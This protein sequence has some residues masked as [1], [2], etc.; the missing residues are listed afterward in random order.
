MRCFDRFIR[1]EQGSAT[2]EFV[3]WV[4]LI[5]ALVAI[6]IDA[7][8]LY[9]THTEMWN[10]ARD[11]ARQMTTGVIATEDDARTCAANGMRLRSDLPYYVDASYDPAAGATVVIALRLND[12]SIMGSSFLFSPLTI[13]G[14]DLAA[15]VK[16]RPDPNSRFGKDPSSAECVTA[17]DPDKPGKDKGPKK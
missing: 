6:V 16:M 3:L 2:I 1:D 7:T 14:G 17:D 13:L 11:T 8:T 5:V 9:I 15:R 12:I 10:V 4:P